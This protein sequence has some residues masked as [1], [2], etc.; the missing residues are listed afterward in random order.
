MTPDERYLSWVEQIDQIANDVRRDG[1]FSLTVR[2]C[3]I[4]PRPGRARVGG[5]TRS[6]SDPRAS[7]SRT[8][9]T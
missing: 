2:W 1:S 5:A 6:K 7:R 8:A 9:W 3:E 4:S